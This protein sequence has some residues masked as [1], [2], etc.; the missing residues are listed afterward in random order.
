[1]DG[2]TAW[3]LSRIGDTTLAEDAGAVLE[4]MP[5][6]ESTANTKLQELLLSCLSLREFQSDTD[7]YFVCPFL[8]FDPLRYHMQWECGWRLKTVFSIRYEAFSSR[9][10]SQSAPLLSASLEYDSVSQVTS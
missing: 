8:K 4:D 5:A 3:L 7:D 10:S 9:C 6:T 1:M 2:L